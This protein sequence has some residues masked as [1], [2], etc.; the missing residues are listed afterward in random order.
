MIK[1]RE[2]IRS[3]S[4]KEMFLA[5][6]LTGS[7]VFVNPVCG[8]ELIQD[9][10]FQRGLI[11]MDPRRTN[12]LLEE[13]RIF[14][15]TNQ[16]HCAW[17]L[18]QWNSHGSIWGVSPVQMDSGSTKWANSYEEVFLGPTDT[19]DSDIRLTINSIS[20]FDGVYRRTGGVVDWPCL[21]VQQRICSPNGGWLASEAGLWI[22][23]L[24]EL[25]FNMDIR[26]AA[27]NN[28][29][30]NG[31]SPLLHRTHFRL[32]FSIMNLG[33]DSNN[34][35]VAG[36]GDYYHFSINMY[37]EWDDFPE[38]AG[39][40]LDNAGS[41]KA[42]Y[43]IGL[44]PFSSNGLVE[45]AWKNLSGDILPLVKSGLQACWNQEYLTNDLA[46]TNENDRYAFYKVN[47]VNIG[48]EATGLS[49]DSIQMKNLSLQAY[50]RHHPRMGLR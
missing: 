12:G 45:G 18:I 25:D 2:S 5:V 20:H 7:F 23:D 31:Y 38:F 39:I 49:C 42:I 4:H 41:L 21:Y 36:Y 35:K 16:T 27:E 13:G 8:F 24:T 34:I 30:T 33:R 48:W 3:K 28:I 50:G 26:L 43:N 17:S 22:S 1:K 11:V 14:Y 9:P 40:R 19:D 44:T 6:M 32:D 10:H 46:Y 29:Q 37:D 15:D 47:A